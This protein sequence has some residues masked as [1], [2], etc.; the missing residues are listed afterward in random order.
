MN[1]IL[2]MYINGA[3]IA[4]SYSMA[5][6]HEKHHVDLHGNNEISANKIHAEGKFNNLN[7]L[8]KGLVR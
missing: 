6:G 7:L 2:N 1:S 4:V 3:L 5:I 8:T